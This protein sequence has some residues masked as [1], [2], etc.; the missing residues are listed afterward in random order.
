MKQV[1]KYLFSGTP[2]LAEALPAVRRMNPEP[3]EF[4]GY[5][6][7]MCSLI[8]SLWVSGGPPQPTPVNHMSIGKSKCNVVRREPVLQLA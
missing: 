8:D 5:V 2:Q 1:A 7:L 6:E 4:D 3:H